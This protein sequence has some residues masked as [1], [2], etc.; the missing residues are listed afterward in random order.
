MKTFLSENTK[1]ASYLLWEST[2]YDNPLSHWYCCENIAYYLETKDITTPK[3]LKEITSR[4][5]FDL[6]YIHFV[7]NIAFHIFINTKNPDKDANWF[8]AEGLLNNAEWCRAITNMAYAL[9]CIRNGQWD[10]SVRSEQ[11]NRLLKD[12]K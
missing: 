9:S 4:N 10:I 3:A 6:D 5:R 11:I 2:K 12:N 1:I 7:R 8:I